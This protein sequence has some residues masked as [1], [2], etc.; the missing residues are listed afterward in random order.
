MTCSLATGST[1]IATILDTSTPHT[2]RNDVDWE[3]MLQH[4]QNRAQ[5]IPAPDQMPAEFCGLNYIQESTTVV[6]SPGRFFFGTSGFA[7][8]DG[9]SSESVIVGKTLV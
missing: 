9:H 1:N 6:K 3:R 2:D 8:G 5:E 7:L 4:V